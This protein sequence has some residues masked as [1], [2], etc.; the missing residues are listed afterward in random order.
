[1]KND[2]KFGKELTCRFKIDMRNMCRHKQLNKKYF[3][4]RS[5]FISTN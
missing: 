1:M 2:A 3:F 5:M 4:I